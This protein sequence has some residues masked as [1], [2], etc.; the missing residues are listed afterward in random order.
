M[1]TIQEVK[2]R[3]NELYRLM[4]SSSE[5]ESMMI[6]GRAE[7]WAFERMTELSE[8]DARKWVEKL[9]STQWLNYI[10]RDEA[11]Y[12]LS[13]LINQDGTKGHHWD[14]QTVKDTIQS[15]GGD[16]EDEPYYNCYA[17]WVMMNTIYSDHAISLGEYIPEE[18]L[19]AVI[20]KMSI[21]KLKDRDRKR[22]IRKYFNL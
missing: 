16:M 6:F 14:Y 17:M 2:D 11:D 13:G 10:T 1:K 19:P 22:F 4:S 15:L 12:I 21:E 3:Y 8:E 20:Y 5:I 7:K 9:E 18:Q